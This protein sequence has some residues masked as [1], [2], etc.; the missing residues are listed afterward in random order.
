MDQ[1]AADA[2]HLAVGVGRDLDSPILIALL[3]R[4]GE[5]F[6]AILDPFDRT[7]QQ[8]RCGDRGDVFGINAKLW[9]KPAADIG[10]GDAQPA[11]VE[12]DVIGQRVLQI[13]SLL[14]RGPDLRFAVGDL[15]QDA[16]AF[17]GMGGAAVDPKILMHD[18]GGLGERRVAVAVSDLVGDDP[19]RGQLAAHRRRALDPAIG[20]RRQHVVI[21]RNQRRRILG[22]IAVARDHD[23]DR[24]ADERHF[25][26]GER[27][28]PALIELCAGIRNT[29]HAPLPQHRGEIVERQ[30]GDD[31]RHCA[32][33]DRIDATDQ[34][35]RMRA[36]HEGR[37]QRAGSG[38][39]IDEA[40]AAG[41]QRK[42]LEPRDP[43][44]DQLAHWPSL[45]IA[46]V[47]RAMTSF[48]V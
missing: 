34:R 46:L 38:N 3:R 45:E 27:E 33:R 19:V 39:V 20:R 11:F 9:A 40:R 7:A 8:S 10:R 17:H 15:R 14:R 32:G 25:T 41:Q 4:I 43:C 31:A 47:A 36:A 12:I 5:M 48:G 18:M 37:V 21:D 30:H 6:A 1:P 16:A 22:D 42:I 26:V 13:V 2:A 44:A 29:H 24:L 35:V 23:G 28:R